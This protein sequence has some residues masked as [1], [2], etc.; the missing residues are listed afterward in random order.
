MANIIKQLFA[1]R[2][3]WYNHATFSYVS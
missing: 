2:R 3:K 1:D